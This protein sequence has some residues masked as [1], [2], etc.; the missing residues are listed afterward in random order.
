MTGAT[1]PFDAICTSCK[2]TKVKHVRPQEVGQHPQIDPDAIDAS[3][4]T[5]FKHV[6]YNCET[7]TYWNP[8]DVL[9]GL[10]ANDGGDDE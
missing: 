10:L 1:I 2:Q 9:S 4:C 7:A 5:S 3:E 6:C 8:V